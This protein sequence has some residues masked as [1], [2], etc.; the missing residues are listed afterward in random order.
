MMFNM[1]FMQKNEFKMFVLIFFVAYN[2][3][4]DYKLPN[5]M[6]SIANNPIVKITVLIH[7][8]I[9]FP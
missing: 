6:V 1:N 4:F 8:L 5:F 2:C 3:L 7:L 9:D